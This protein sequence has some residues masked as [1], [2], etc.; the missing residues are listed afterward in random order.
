MLSFDSILTLHTSIWS[1]EFVKSLNIN[2][3][4][5]I[6]QVLRLY[7]GGQLQEIRF[8]GL[9]FEFGFWFQG[10]KFWWHLYLNARYPLFFP[11]PQAR[12]SKKTQNKPIYLFLKAHALGKKLEFVERPHKMGRV[13]LVGLKTTPPLDS[14][15]NSVCEI[16]IRLFPHG[17]NLIVRSQGKQ[18]SLKPIK[19]LGELDHLEVPNSCRSIDGLVAEFEGLNCFPHPDSFARSSG[20]LSS[21]FIQKVDQLKRAINQVSKSLEGKEQLPWDRVGA[22]LVQNQG[23]ELPDEWSDF[24]PSLEWDSFINYKENL[25]WNI[26]NCFHKAKANRQKIVRARERQEELQR[27]LD[28]LNETKEL[29]TPL[30]AIP[31]LS[32]YVKARKITLEGGAEAWVGKNAHEN[33]RL[34]RQAKSWDIWVHLLNETSSHGL[35]R[36]HRGLEVSHVSMV[37]VGRWLVQMTFGEKSKRLKGDRFQ[38]VYT[39]CRYVSPIK[40]DKLGRVTYR[41]EKVITFR[42]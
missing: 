42:F 36:R 38:L 17:Q 5:I 10:K 13:I 12:L 30:K 32:T 14:E 22:L 20:V 3:L 16:E 28:K 35:I 18:L 19:D 6:C 34:L 40:G 11:L 39:E 7:R 24:A 41:N 29:P 4:D 37:D 9:H 25:A 26:Q 1:E 23:L 27:Q 31:P 8:S 15:K 33:I 21:P 2:E